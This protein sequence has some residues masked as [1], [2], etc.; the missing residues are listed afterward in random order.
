MFVS[1]STQPYQRGKAELRLPEPSV[2][3]GLKILIMQKRNYLDVDVKRKNVEERRLS[4]RE[5]EVLRLLADG[6]APSE[7][8]HALRLSLKTVQ[9][10]CARL[11]QKLGSQNMTQLIRDAVLPIQRNP[12][13][14][15]R[16]NKLMSDAIPSRETRNFVHQ[17]FLDFAASR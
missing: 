9:G 7:I 17:H 3:W 8:A 11:K 10:Y 16:L 2:Q 5:K 4:A 13:F 14:L 6:N 12:I 1:I 15:H